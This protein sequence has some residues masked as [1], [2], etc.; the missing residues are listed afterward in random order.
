MVPMNAL[1][2]TVLRP[3]AGNWINAVARLHRGLLLSE[4]KPLIS[5]TTWMDL[6]AIF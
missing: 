1:T 4:R 5:I 6:N 3:S 2:Q